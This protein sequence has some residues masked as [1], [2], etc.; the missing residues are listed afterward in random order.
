ME[1]EDASSVRFG[2]AE[3]ED[4]FLIECEGS[5]MHGHSSR[6]TDS[7]TLGG[8]LSCKCVEETSCVSPRMCLSGQLDG[9]EA[10]GARG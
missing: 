5:L 4:Q 9:N 8:K 2:T 7:E 6:H 10:D 1:T 3:G